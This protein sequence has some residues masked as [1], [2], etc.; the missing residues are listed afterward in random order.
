MIL[1]FKLD[2]LLLVGFFFFHVGIGRNGVWQCQLLMTPF[3]RN[4][5]EAMVPILFSETTQMLSSCSMAVFMLS[6]LVTN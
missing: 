3:G 5:I 1:L 4:I 2:F 6:R